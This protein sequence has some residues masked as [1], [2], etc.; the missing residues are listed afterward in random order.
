MYHIRLISWKHNREH[1]PKIN[2]TT[3]S[4]IVFEKF[5][6]GKQGKE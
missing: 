4:L 5:C 3:V 1:R 6:D 2:L